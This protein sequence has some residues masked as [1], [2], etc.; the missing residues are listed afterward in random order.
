MPTHRPTVLILASDPAFAREITAHWPHGPAPHSDVPE[1]VVLDEGFSR[2]LQGNNYDLAIADAS[3][4]GKK[5]NKDERI[6]LTRRLNKDLRQSLAA[7]G[8]PAI[9]IHSDPSR[10]FYNIHGAIIDLRRESVVWP[11]IAGLVGREILRRH[12]A[13]V[14]ARDAENTSAAAQG[15]ATLGRFM[16]EMRTNINNAL[17]TVLGN[18]ELLIQEPGLPATV[19]SQA[20]AIRNM[21]LRLHEVFQ[22]F[23]S[24]ETEL[25]V[26]SRGS[27]GK[28]AHAAAGKS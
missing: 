24:I 26:A 28:A 13:E 19:Q 10:D 1:F 18:A 9:V 23:T 7:A 11:A 14:R 3:S 2:G 12:Q 17:T 6:P 16:V 8:K 5:K 15:E 20:D 21:A 25:N 22:R 4:V 27:A